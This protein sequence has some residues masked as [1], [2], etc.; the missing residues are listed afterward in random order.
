M[1][2]FLS[3]TAVILLLSGCS[4]LE[5]NVDYDETYNFDDASKVVVAHENKGNANTLLNDRIINA[6]NTN[7]ESKQYK[8]SSQ[9][10]ADLIFV[11]KTNV[12]DKTQLST[13]YYTMGRMYRFGG[14]VSSTTAYNYTQGTM[15]IDALNPKTG[16]IVWRGVATK[17]LS[18]KK[19]PQEKT[20]AINKVV[21]KIM[22]KFPSKG[23][24]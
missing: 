21:N 11:F 3:F 15:V 24:K 18:E 19:T 16:K 4:T 6:L 2:S 17:E 14:G 8:K 10:D 1:K 7:L 9:K 12:K 13:D 5:V 23:E 22:E 20:Q